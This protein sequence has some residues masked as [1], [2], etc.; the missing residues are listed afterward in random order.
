MISLIFTGSKFEFDFINDEFLEEKQGV[1]ETFGATVQ[2][3][4]DGDMDKQ[5]SF[6]G[7]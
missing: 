1:I 6:H 2:S 7:Y 3:I 4:L 5:I